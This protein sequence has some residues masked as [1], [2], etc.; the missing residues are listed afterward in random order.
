[1]KKEETRKSRILKRE[2]AYCI[3][4]FIA[5][6]HS[7][8]VVAIPVVIFSKL[9]PAKNIFL[10]LNLFIYIVVA[11][12]IGVLIRKV[13]TYFYNEMNKE[14][15]M[16]AAEFRK[17]DI[18]K[19]KKLAREN[20]GNIKPF[21]N[22]KNGKV[23]NDIA[24]KNISQVVVDSVGNEKVSI[25]VKLKNGRYTLPQYVK[26]EDL[27]KILDDNT[28]REITVC[29]VTDIKLENLDKENVTLQIAG[30]D[31][32]LWKE[33]KVTDERIYDVFYLK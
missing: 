13:G 17:Q 27:V 31:D 3:A 24:L 12:A 30:N 18:E 4:N 10:F 11:C 28:K 15:K 32:Y 26:I 21:V 23:I 16:Q 20:E 7:I 33:E 9:K 29:T 2:R 1:M 8:I 6:M 14:L 25:R 22:I 5:I 19:I